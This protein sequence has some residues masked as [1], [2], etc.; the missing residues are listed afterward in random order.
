MLALCLQTVRFFLFFLPFS[1][2]YN[3]FLIAGHDVLS[4]RNS[5]KEAFYKVMVRCVCGEEAFHS[6]VTNSESF[7]N[8][9]VWT[10][11]FMC[12]FQLYTPS[13]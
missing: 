8:L 12:A 11:N 2:S 5:C 9:Y 7:M 6:P 10:G 13:S 4:K 3:F 1:K